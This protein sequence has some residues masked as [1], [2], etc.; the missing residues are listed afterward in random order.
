MSSARRF[1][2]KELCVRSSSCNT[3]AA[4]EMSVITDN[5]TGDQADKGQI[6]CLYDMD[7]PRSDN[8]NE[9]YLYEGTTIFGDTKAF[10][11]L[12]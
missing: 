4:I 6:T 11:D 7:I 2:Q 8:F 12:R 9:T 10:T 1:L 3:S 5:G